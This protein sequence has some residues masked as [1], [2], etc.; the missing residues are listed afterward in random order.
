[1]PSQHN[2]DLV[3]STTE[4]INRS[5]AVIIVEYQGIS[6][7]DQVTLRA[8]IKAA[9]GEL[10]V[11]KNRLVSLALKSRFADKLPS[12]IETVLE[13]PSAI[14]FGYED[15]VAVT[16]FLTDFAK[17]HDTIKPKVGVLLAEDASST[18]KVMS[19]ADITALATLP[20][21]DQLL[22]MLVVQLQSPIQGFYNVLKGNLSGLARVLNGIKEQKETAN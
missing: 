3:K 21:K 10:N 1:M 17:T 8:G 6:V 15:A 14:L 11:T 9:G 20:S 5:K 13:G 12:E 18:D 7:N 4:K 16:K 2:Q 22:T 19:P